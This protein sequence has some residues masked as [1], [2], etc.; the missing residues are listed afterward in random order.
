MEHGERRREPLVLL[1]QPVAPADPKVPE[2]VLVGARH[3]SVVHRAAET[4]PR[5]LGTAPRP[6]MFLPAH[7]A[8]GGAPGPRTRTPSPVHGTPR[9]HGPSPPG[10]TNFRVVWCRMS[11]PRSYCSVDCLKNWRANDTRS[12]AGSDSTGGDGLHRALWSY[13]S[14]SSTDRCRRLADAVCG[15]R[16]QCAPVPAVGS[17]RVG[18]PRGVV[19]GRRE[20]LLALEVAPGEVVALATMGVPAR[21]ARP[22][23]RDVGAEDGQAHVEC[24]QV[25]QL[26]GRPP[27]S[28]PGTRMVP[29]VEAPSR[30]WRWC[31]ATG[32]VHGR[33]GSGRR[34]SGRGPPGRDSG[35]YPSGGPGREV[36]R[37]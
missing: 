35:Y 30:G 9:P 12:S 23:R 2:V 21:P 11:G 36:P 14:R 13:V 33:R 32:V 34:T 27:P 6:P 7:L 8:S 20:D 10:V 19:G 17:G 25:P 31:P 28:C 24:L 18:L 15:A 22:F 5:A 26:H 4:P 1:P 37:P 16:S 3:V 29:G